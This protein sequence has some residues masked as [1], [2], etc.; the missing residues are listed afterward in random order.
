MLTLSQI[1]L[2]TQVR[3]F[4]DE[5]I[6]LLGHD[7]GL[8]LSKPEVSFYIHRSTSIL[9]LLTNAYLW[10]NNKKYGLGFKKINLA[11]G[12]IV[13]EI[14]TGILMYYF[15]FPFLTQPI[16]LVVASLLFGIQLYIYL[17][18]RHKKKIIGLSKTP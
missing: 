12:C 4:V 13:F 6:K 14:F 10:F 15:E 17:E 2:G 1:I 11:M 5:Q 7:K 3:Q 8:W 9:V 16:H 18:I